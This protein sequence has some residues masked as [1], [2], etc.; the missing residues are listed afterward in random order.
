MTDDERMI[1]K[2]LEDRITR[3]EKE[4]QDR[5]TEIM[6][7]ISEISKRN[8]AKDTEYA[9]MKREIKII[10]DYIGSIDPRKKA[11]RQMALT[12][13]AVIF[14]GM[15]VTSAIIIFIVSRQIVK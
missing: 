2:G 3:H 9:L 7:K 15:Q 11:R 10:S 4:D 5:N 1:I 6:Q 13:L 12:T 14:A 8:S